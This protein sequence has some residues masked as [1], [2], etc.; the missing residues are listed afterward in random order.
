[1]TALERLEKFERLKELINGPEAEEFKN[2]WDGRFFTG[3]MTFLF[4]GTPYNLYFYKGTLVDVELGKPVNG[5]YVGISGDEE[6]WQEFFTKRNFQLAISVKH[7]ER[8]FEQLG[9]ALANRQNNTV[10]AQVMRLIA[11][12]FCE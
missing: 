3:D 8:P 4:D 12:A 1:M 11:K 9:S 5:Y 10:V 2:Y 7:N 6:Q